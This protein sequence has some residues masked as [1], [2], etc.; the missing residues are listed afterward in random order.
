M[1]HFLKNKLLAALI[2]ALFCPALA[3]AS[4]DGNRQMQDPERE[5]AVAQYRAQTQKRE[6]YEYG[7]IYGIGGI[8]NGDVEENFHWQDDPLFEDPET[9]YQVWI[10][11]TQDHLTDDEEAQLLEIMKPLAAYGNVT[12][13]LN[14][15]KGDA[16][17]YYDKLYRDQGYAD[18]SG[19]LFVICEGSHTVSLFCQG[20]VQDHIDGQKAFDIGRKDYYTLKGAFEKNGVF[21]SFA[22]ERLTDLLTFLSTSLRTVNQ[23][24]GCA[25]WVMDGVQ[26]FSADKRQEILETARKLA[27]DTNIVFATGDNHANSGSWPFE[28]PYLYTENFLQIYLNK[29][30]STLVPFLSLKTGESFSGAVSD[31]A[32]KNLAQKLIP[33]YDEDEIGSWMEQIYEAVLESRSHNDISVTADS[34]YQIRIIDTEDL[35]SDEEQQQL[36]EIMEPVAEYGNVAFESYASRE[37]GKDYCRTN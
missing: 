5:E 27:N 23:E 37:S 4:A 35:L 7:Q 32:L 26:M 13:D 16:A 34:G 19:I 15:S 3:L 14:S 25:A 22:K 29:N 12:F 31:N 20:K 11:D 6:E 10:R 9:H 30:E 33:L 8:S 36:L 2:L 17:D 21:F 28:T 18:D 1:M 24:S